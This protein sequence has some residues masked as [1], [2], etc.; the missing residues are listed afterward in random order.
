MIR[1][2]R[3]IWPPWWALLAAAFVFL[4]GQCG[5]LLIEW[6]VGIPLFSMRLE[7]DNKTGLVA[8]S[9]FLAAMYAF[10]RVWTFHPALRPGYCQW[11]CGTPWTSRKALPLG[12]VH[13][14][15]Q[16][17]LL[18]AIAIGLNWPRLEWQSLTIATA[19]SRGLRA[20]PRRRLRSHAR[21]AL[22]PT[23][24]HLRLLGFTFFFNS[25]PLLYAGCVAA[26]YGLAATL[27]LRASSLAGFPW[28]GSRAGTK[29][30]DLF[31]Y[32]RRGWPYDHLGPRLAG[33]ASLSRSRG[34]AAFRACWPAGGCWPISWM[35]R[36]K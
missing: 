3:A 10:Y 32:R 27:G 34:H 25:D 28:E 31:D 35:L 20:R 6:I 24:S 13:L 8:L 9:G 19:L 22:G 4:G 14:V 30:N 21:E 1:W 11:L 36:E 2:L 33:M 7:G 16:D 5:P 29:V 17:L 23:P 26:T 12:P 15:W 18:L